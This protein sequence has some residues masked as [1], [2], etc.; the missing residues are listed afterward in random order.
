VTALSATGAGLLGWY[1]VYCKPQREAWAELHLRRKGI[2]AFHPQLELP[3][4]ARGHRRC[5]PLFPNYLFVQIDLVTRFYD[6]AWSPGVKAF[7]G[8]GGAPTPLDEAVVA[9]LKRNATA[10]G[11]LR[12]RP[13]L[14]AGQEVEIVDGP[15]AGLIAII[16]NPPD[17]KGRI[18]VLMRLLKGRPVNMQIPIRL[19]RSGW[20]A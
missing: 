8:A 11:R 5:V 18:R 12:A 1:V 10:D 6:V 20:V 2:E 3:Q 15:F 4:Y 16:Q 14:K 19:V 7:V 17:A 9:F 13:D